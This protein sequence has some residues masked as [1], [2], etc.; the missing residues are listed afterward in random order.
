MLAQSQICFGGGKLNFHWWSAIIPYIKLLLGLGIKYCL[1]IFFPLFKS[2]PLFH[3]TCFQS[4]FYWLPRTVCT[5]PHRRL[6]GKEAVCINN[7]A[8][9]PHSINCLYCSSSPEVHLACIYSNINFSHSHVLTISQNPDQ[10][11]QRNARLP[12]FEI[13]FINDTFPFPTT[14][15]SLHGSLLQLLGKTSSLLLSKKLCERFHDPLIH[16][17][18]NLMQSFWCWVYYVASF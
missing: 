5:C 4:A 3:Y 2:H 1:A 17:K 13:V 14:A 15:F 7:T 6:S 18:G 12:K 16:F 8:W 10:Y 11:W 9:Q